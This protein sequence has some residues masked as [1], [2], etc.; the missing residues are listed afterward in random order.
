MFEV[1][2]VSDVTVVVIL[3]KAIDANNTKTFKQDLADALQGKQKVIFDLEKLTFIDS[4]G[5]GAML[6]FLRTINKDNGQLKLCNMAKTIR[7]IFELVRMH[8]VF[9]IC[10]TREEA[11]AALK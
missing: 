1:E 5:L 11:I 4:S 8:K 10:N 6:S 3:E 7:T 2:T 9:D